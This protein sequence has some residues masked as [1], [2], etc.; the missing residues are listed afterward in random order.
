MFGSSHEERQG[1]AFHPTGKSVSFH[2]EIFMT[3]SYNY[4]IHLVLSHIYN[5]RVL[6]YSQICNYILNEYAESYQDKMIKKMVSDLEYIEKIGFYK[7]ESYYFLT[8]AGVGYLKKYGI[9]PVGKKNPEDAEFPSS[10]LSASKI[11]MKESVIEHQLALNE[12]VLNFGCL[13]HGFNYKY[14]DEIYI[15]SVIKNIRPDG[16]LK[17]QDDYYFLEMDMNT[18]RQSQL[19]GKW[20][21]Y[22][23]FLNS[24]EYFMLS[25][26]I[27]VLFITNNVSNPAPRIGKLRDYILRYLEGP[28]SAK[29]NILVN[30]AEI[31]LPCIEAIHNNTSLKSVSGLIAPTGYTVKASITGDCFAGEEFGFYLYKLS[32]S[33]KLLQENNVPCEFV[34]DDFRNQNMYVLKKIR[35]LPKISSTF[36]MQKLRDLKY[37]VIVQ[38]EETAFKAVK[39]LNAAYP[40]LYFTTANRLSSGSLPLSLFKVST[41]G[42]VFRI[43]SDDLQNVVLEKN[44]DTI[45]VNK[46]RD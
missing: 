34:L 4:N 46:E 8:K 17:I 12:F 37:I 21:N 39:Q 26:R 31:L 9:I 22:N 32:K 36:K 7:K 45:F 44:M 29:F 13:D 23:R 2:A 41:S 24:D 16:I 5:F 42:N 28:L 20:D 14:Y 40:N 33:N 6:S 18:E 25:G 3:D 1:K 38:D 30:K 35:L 19:T 11:K 43:I 15:S 27:T 10:F